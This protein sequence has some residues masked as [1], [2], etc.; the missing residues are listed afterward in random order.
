MKLLGKLILICWPL[1]G[2]EGYQSLPRACAEKDRDGHEAL[3]Q[4]VAAALPGRLQVVSARL[5]ESPRHRGR[6]PELGG[7]FG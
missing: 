2:V 7:T 1:S 5:Q 4:D 6:E 3:C